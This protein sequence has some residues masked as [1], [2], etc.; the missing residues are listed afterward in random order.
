M[1]R[2]PTDALVDVFADALGALAEL[3]DAALE[4]LAAFLRLAWTVA[5]ADPWAL[6]EALDE[7]HPHWT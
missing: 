1:T 2:S 7:P 5:T 4:A 6:D 3:V